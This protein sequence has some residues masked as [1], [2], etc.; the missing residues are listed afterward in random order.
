VDHIG[1]FLPSLKILEITL[2]NRF[3]GSLAQVHGLEEVSLIC[4]GAYLDAD[5]GLTFQH[6]SLL[7]I[8]SA[9]TLT[10]LYLNQVWLE[11]DA[12]LEVFT[13][14]EHLVTKD[15]PIDVELANLIRDLPGDLCSLSS[16]VD[17]WIE[18]F[19]HYRFDL[20]D[21]RCLAHLKKICLSVTY[22]EPDEGGPVTDYIDDCM[23]VVTKMVNNMPLLEE[24]E[25]Y[26]GFDIGRIHVLGRLPN[27]R[28]LKWIVCEDLT[29]IISEDRYEKC[30][31]SQDITSRD[32]TSRAFEI[33]ARIGKHVESVKIEFEFENRF[34]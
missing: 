12:S 26:G 21:C 20:L 6:R 34:S 1:R 3:S 31:G 16:S 11:D 2:P 27:L 28:R 22:V 4:P 14:L 19:G 13:R 8:A 5:T 18:E 9:E 29:A 25:L 17:T 32:I 24:V 30:V 33:F 7:P 15:W 10:R 23:E